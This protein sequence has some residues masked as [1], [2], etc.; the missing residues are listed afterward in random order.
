MY[1]SI[2]IAL[3]IEFV[4]QI[5]GLFQKEKKNEKGNLKWTTVT[6]YITEYIL[7]LFLHRHFH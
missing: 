5:S 1:W 2:V 3:Q 6:K 4:S 7:L